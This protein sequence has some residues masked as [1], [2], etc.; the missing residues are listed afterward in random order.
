MARSNT[1]LSFKKQIPHMTLDFYVRKIKARAKHV[2]KPQYWSGINVDDTLCPLVKGFI[3]T[4][5]NLH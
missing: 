4:C 2:L 3:H 5:D 1:N